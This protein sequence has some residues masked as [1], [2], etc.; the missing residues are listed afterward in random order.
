[1]KVL[2]K[3][4]ARRLDRRVF[5]RGI[6]CALRFAA[7]F[8]LSQGKV[9]GETTPFGVGFVAATGEDGA[10]GLCGAAGAAVGAIV[11]WRLGDGFKYLAACIL[12]LVAAKA[13]SGTMLAGTRFFGSAVAAGSLAV[14]GFVFVAS[15]GFRMTATLAYIC[16]VALAAGSALMIPAALDRGKGELSPRE[17]SLRAASRL[18]FTALLL[19]GLSSVPFFAGMTVGRTAA[20]VLVLSAAASGGM[21][22]GAATGV[23]L[24]AVFDIGG[25]GG[26]YAMCYGAAGLLAGIAGGGSR[27]YAAIAYV[28]ATA[29]AALADGAHFSAMYETFVASV[30]FVLIPADKLGI[31]DFLAPEETGSTVAVE[32]RELAAR[33]RAV[34]ELL[35]ETAKSLVPNIPAPPSPDRAIVRTVAR[36]CRGCALRAVCWEREREETFAQ[37]RSSSGKIS[38]RGGVEEEDLAPTFRA[39]CLR[40]DEFRAAMGEEYRVA[41]LERRK[42]SEDVRRR[43][44]VAARMSDAARY[45]ADAAEETARGLEFDGET[46]RLARRAL[47]SENCAAELSA[48][49]LPNGR[50]CVEV[51]AQR[52]ASGVSDAVGRSL[53][54]E[55]CVGESTEDGH[56]LLY[57]RGKFDLTAAAA[58]RRKRGSVKNGD[59]GSYFK[60]PHGKFACALADGMGSG[61][62]A[63]DESTAA[64]RAAENLLRAGFDAE[65]A[66]EAVLDIAAE[67]GSAAFSTLDLLVVDDWTAKGEL[68]KL[69]AAATYVR[70]D[71]KVVKASGAESC[72]IDGARPKCVTINLAD[73]DR[74][75]M[76][77]DGVAD[78]E[79]D[80]WLREL[81]ARS[82]GDA[83][84]LA[85]SIVANA[86][87]RTDEADDMTAVVLALD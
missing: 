16:E 62:E 9:F 73:C 43:N 15:D 5:G 27:L 12:A 2:E 8:V 55:M 39:R 46:Q 52:V 19:L 54:C 76:V 51:Y 86:A 40:L 71:G 42:Q 36:V 1:M 31:V 32:R 80:G 34:G 37:L 78:A 84:E 81:I 66:A 26:F 4:G 58:T 35:S 75:V 61:E 10:E 23:A 48:Y 60:V 25:G 69:G 49:R 22:T 50:R 87:R 11:A 18:I 41:Q 72:A 47:R 45:F 6:K 21:G 68:V 38:A 56:V 63:A 85:R 57:E 7:G 53:G 59:C 74:V 79:E 70:V 44:G 33:H 3:A 82:D 77:T 17:R 20:T 30:L 14:V 24:G 65:H 13:F 67:R 29:V 83:E 28:L 64:V